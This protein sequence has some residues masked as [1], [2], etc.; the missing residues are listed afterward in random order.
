MLI[1]VSFVALAFGRDAT[2]WH[3]ARAICSEELLQWRWPRILSALI[4]GVM[5]AV[6]GCII[7]RL[8]GNPIASPEVLVSFGNRVWRGADAVPCAGNAFGWLMPA[9]SIG[10]AV[11]LMI[12]LIASGRGGFSPHRMLLA[13]M[14]LSTAFTM[15][16][17]MQAS[18][19]P[20]MA[21]I[22]AWISGS[23]YNATG[24]QVVHS[25]IVMIVLLAI[26]PLCRRW[27]TILPLG[28]KP[29]VRSAWR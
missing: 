10:A 24:S 21:K 26:V 20:R 9:G 1:I 4:A 28:A 11:T 14:A 2:G 16:L 17:M 7:Q 18:G 27:M 29:H 15:L 19:D 25:G 3:W 13:G 22:L 8:T 23:T 12:I 6:A 5:L